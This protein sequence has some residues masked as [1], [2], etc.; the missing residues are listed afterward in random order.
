[1]H[2]AVDLAAGDGRGP[3]AGLATDH[4]NLTLL[5]WPAGHVVPEHV[6][7]VCDVAYVVLHGSATLTVDGTAAGLRAPMAI[8][9]P[10]DARR[11][12][13]AGPDGVR[14]VTVHRAR[15]G[16]AIDRIAR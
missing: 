1:V 6:N 14:Y 13:V 11:E 5:S 8:V 4:L 10:R 2:D 7:A 9:V 16:L 3:L 12:L 15:S